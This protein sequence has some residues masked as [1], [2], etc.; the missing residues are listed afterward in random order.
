MRDASYSRLKNVTL[1]Y[2]L[3]M[4]IVNY[5]FINNLRIFFSGDNI[6]TIPNFYPGQDPEAGLGEGNFYPF[7]S[8]YTLGVDLKF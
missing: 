8:V 7:V 1:G 5:T 4:R 2:T 6:L 3:P